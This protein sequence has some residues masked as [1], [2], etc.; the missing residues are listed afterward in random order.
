MESSSPYLQNID[1]KL[2]FFRH[3][4]FTRRCNVI[5][6]Y[7]KGFKRSIL[8]LQKRLSGI[9]CYGLVVC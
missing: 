3:A 1:M 7:L 5:E 4:T 2:Y 8:S 9:S 6:R